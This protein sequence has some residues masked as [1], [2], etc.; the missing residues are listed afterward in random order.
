M[1]VLQNEFERGLHCLIDSFW[2]EPKPSCGLACNANAPCYSMVTS[3]LPILPP[4][5]KTRA[6]RRWDIDEGVVTWQ[7]KFSCTAKA[8]LRFDAATHGC[9]LRCTSACGMHYEGILSL[10]YLFSFDFNQVHVTPLP[11]LRPHLSRAKLD[12]TLHFQV[13]QHV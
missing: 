12:A 9:S 11:A 8:L 3:H 7:K 5:D 10:R 1:K 4:G 6:C 2:N 13:D